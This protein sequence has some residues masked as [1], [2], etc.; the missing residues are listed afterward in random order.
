M[1]YWEQNEPQPQPEP[2]PKWWVIFLALASVAVVL[3]CGLLGNSDTEEKINAMK[4]STPQEF[5]K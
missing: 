4:W 1:R 5:L 3:A 2:M